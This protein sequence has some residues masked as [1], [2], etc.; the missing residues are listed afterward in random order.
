MEHPAGAGKVSAD[1]SGPHLRSSSCGRL[2]RCSLCEFP[3]H[4]CIVPPRN[5]LLI[6]PFFV[7]YR[8][9]TFFVKKVSA[10]RCTYLYP[11]TTRNLLPLGWGFATCS[12][13][14]YC[15]I[16]LAGEI[17]LLSRLCDFTLVFLK[18]FPENRNDLTLT[19]SEVFSPYSQ[20]PFLS[21]P[22]QER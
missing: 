15:T 6:W 22:S 10:P 1:Y 8:K 16:Y 19:N 12:T 9:T 13:I 7:D 14:P 5:I 17:I 4:S 21:F 20:R 2:L 18:Y 11:V 3:P